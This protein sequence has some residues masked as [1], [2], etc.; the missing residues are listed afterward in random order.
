MKPSPKVGAGAMEPKSFHVDSFKESM[1]DKQI[2]SLIDKEEERS[3]RTFENISL[4]T[5]SD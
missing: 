4:R 2:Q 5:I 1:D 3:G